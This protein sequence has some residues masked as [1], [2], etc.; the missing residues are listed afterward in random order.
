MGTP[1]GKNLAIGGNLF[2]LGG[3]FLTLEGNYFTPNYPKELIHELSMEGNVLKSG[4]KF[5]P[6][7]LKKIFQKA[8]TN[9]KS[10]D[11]GVGVNY[12]EKVNCCFYHNSS[13]Y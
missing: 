12:H 9:E 11:N 5:Y 3:K 2:T 13:F 1:P 8:F 10:D 4:A 6:M 7:D